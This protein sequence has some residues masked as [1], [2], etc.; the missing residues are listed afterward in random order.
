MKRI[1][2]SVGVLALLGGPL[3]EHSLSARAPQVGDGA[4][5]DVHGGS[6]SFEGATNVFATTVRGES[7]ALDGSAI[8][9]ES[10]QGL[11]LEQIEAILP[12]ASLRTGLKVRDEHMR[13]YIFQTADGQTPDLRFSAERAE[14][15]AN[16]STRAALCVATGTLAIRG[17]VRP[18]SMTFKVSKDNDRFR[19]S[20]EGKVALSTY[21]IE[22][23]SQF[24]VKTEDEVKLHL[25]VT[26][27]SGAKAVATAGSREE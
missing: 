27:R 4:A 21:G 25:D 19:V 13:Q 12:V 16:G 2:L 17:I 9:R 10:A 1:V 26:A 3:V 8:V 6:I 5:A 23:P 11:Q 15:S 22:R 18:F 20:G 14:C 7:S 24:G